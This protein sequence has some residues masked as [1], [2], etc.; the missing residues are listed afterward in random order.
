MAF[1]NLAWLEGLDGLVSAVSCLLFVGYSM[2]SLN[3]WILCTPLPTVIS[4]IT[5][6]TLPLMKLEKFL[7][8]I[9]QYA[10][11]LMEYKYGS[12]SPFERGLI[13]QDITNTDP[14]L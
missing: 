12:I 11:A 5:P 2:Q 14:L 13:L 1:G 10:Y 9:L 6:K 4:L 8:N 3:L 7:E